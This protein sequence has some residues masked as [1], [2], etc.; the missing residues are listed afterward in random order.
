MAGNRDEFSTRV[1]EILAKRANEHCSNRECGIATSG[2][3]Q[4][5]D[6]AIN[7]GVAAHI[8]A[9]SPG[10]PRYNKSLTSE[11]RT[12]ISN[13]I[14]LCQKCAKLIDSDV[15]TYPEEILRIWK[16]EHEAKIKA[17]TEGNAR[18]DKNSRSPAKLYI[19]QIFSNPSADNNACVLDIRVSNPGGSD[20]MINA[21]EF[22]VLESVE[23]GLLGHAEYS[24]Q[25]DLDIG[26]MRDYGL[27]G[28]C[29][30]A[31]ILKP[32]EADRFAVILS[33]KQSSASVSGWRFITLFKTNAGNIHGPEIEVWLPRPEVIRSIDEVACLWVTKAKER[34]SDTG[35]EFQLLATRPTDDVL[36]DVFSDFTKSGGGALAYPSLYDGYETLVMFGIT[37]GVYRG[38]LPL[39]QRS[40]PGGTGMVKSGG[41]HPRKLGGSLR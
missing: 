5:E 20:L 15:K 19:D 14:W 16:R 23:K 35:K 39:W 13:A 37:L 11:D 33:D 1:K 21:I 29:Q 25:Y 8:T 12:S 26:R 9:A 36:P 28:E 40:R 41:S 27:R 32:G 22:Q 10:G 18:S 2:P 3:H 6:K 17:E 24:A 30:V 34:N 38:P 31:Q 7:L 4:D